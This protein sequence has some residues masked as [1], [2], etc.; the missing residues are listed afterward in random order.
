MSPK[1]TNKPRQAILYLPLYYNSFL[2]S[3]CVKWAE[4]CIWKLE[5]TSHHSHVLAQWL[6]EKT[7]RP[8]VMMLQAYTG[9]LERFACLMYIRT[10][11]CEFIDDA[12]REVFTQKHR[13]PSL[14]YLPITSEHLYRYM[15]LGS[16]HDLSYLRW[17]SA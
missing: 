2:L 13:S 9:Q 8:R 7:S 15:L 1:L 16:I 6:G 17:S 12:Q 4:D 5:G 10:T 3:T 11:H 14:E